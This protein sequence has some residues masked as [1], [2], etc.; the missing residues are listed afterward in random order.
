[1]RRREKMTTTRRRRRRSRKSN[2]TLFADNSIS[3]ADK[4]EKI[5]RRTG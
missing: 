4:E 3:G 1:M 2:H 5:V